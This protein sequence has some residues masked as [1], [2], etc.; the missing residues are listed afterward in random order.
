M[1]PDFRSIRM[2][3]RPSHQAKRLIASSRKK[4]AGA[5]DIGAGV[6]DIGDGIAA[7]A[8]GAATGVVVI[9]EALPAIVREQ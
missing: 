9:G 1:T 4:C 5:A 8:G 2:L 3:S 7:V 6:A